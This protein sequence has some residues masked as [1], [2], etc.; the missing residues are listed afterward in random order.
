MGTFPNDL[1]LKLTYL[2]SNKTTIIEVAR[3]AGVS[4]STVS[5]VLLGGNQVKEETKALILNTIDR[6]GYERNNIASSMR[7]D[8][9][10]M[11]ML[12]TPDIAN[13]FWSEVARGVQDTVEQQGYSVVLANSDWDASREQRFLSTARRNRFDALV[14][15][16]AAV[17]ERDLLAHGAPIVIL[18]L[19]D[20][21]S[22]LD[23]VG[24]DSYSGTM[25][26]LDHLYDL[27]HRR[28]GFIRGKHRSG[29]GHARHRAFND[30]LNHHMLPADP[31]LI[32]EAP[33]DL[34]GGQRAAVTLLQR[35][36]RP[37][38]IF[39]ANDVLAL[40][41][42]QTAREL[43]LDIPG[44]LSVVGM[45]DI[46]AAATAIPPLTTV[47]KAKYDTGAMAA[48]FLLDRLNSASAITPR[49][50]VVPCH[51]V[52]R[53]STAPPRKKGKK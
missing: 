8:R 34:A 31:S 43:G 7:T 12:A 48:R 30:F 22:A 5:R 47:A 4:K 11:I 32:V 49:R 51:L 37:S 6:L 15:N 13:P 24:S 46:Y 23:M 3:A 38:A 53:G 19:R 50:H 16:P 44:D 1:L 26:A 20:D 9:T 18:G 40:G 33:F 27:G 35:P 39:A 52:V 2:M 17:S 36:D 14:I 25:T 10:W 29:R 41:A 45:D 21:F 42:M 28:I